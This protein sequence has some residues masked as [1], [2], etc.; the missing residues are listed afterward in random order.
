MANSRIMLKCIKSK[1]TITAIITA[2]AYSKSKGT[3]RDDP[4]PDEISY[5]IQQLDSS[6]SYSYSSTATATASKY[7]SYS[8]ERTRCLTQGPVPWRLKPDPWSRRRDDELTRAGANDKSGRRTVWWSGSWWALTTPDP[9]DD[10]LTPGRR[11]GPG[12]RPDPDDD[13]TLVLRWWYR[14]WTTLDGWVWWRWTSDIQIYKLLYQL[15]ATNKLAFI[16][17]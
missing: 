10:D 7:S 13:L 6:Y 9:D 5:S 1:F 12:T 4:G 15:S 2:L 11:P 3:W 17:K 8:Y 16:Y 14:R